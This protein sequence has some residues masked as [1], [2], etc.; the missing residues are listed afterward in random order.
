MNVEILPL[1]IRE[2]FMPNCEDI[3]KKAIENIMPL[4]DESIEPFHASVDGHKS[5]YY[6]NSKLANSVD[7]TEIINFVN[8]QSQIYWDSLHYSKLLKPYVIQSWANITPNGGKLSVHSHSP[9]P[10]AGVFYLNATPEMG[11]FIIENPLDA[12]LKCQ[13]YEFD[14]KPK[15]FLNHEISI[16]SGKLILFPGY[17]KHGTLPNPTD[18]L[19]I[20]LGLNIGCEGQVKF[21]HLI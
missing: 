18:D 14:F 16:A 21:C 11:N 15:N 8:E 20:V 7:L 12:L 10:I 5:L 13:P 6:R 17:L 19:R 4:F 3:I 1:T 9:A 2:V